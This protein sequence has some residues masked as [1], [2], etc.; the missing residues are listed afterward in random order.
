[1]FSYNDDDNEEV[2]E[3]I[4]SNYDEDESERESGSE[5]E[6]EYENED[7]S[8]NDDNDDGDDD[9]EEEEEENSGSEDDSDYNSEEE[10]EETIRKEKEDKYGFVIN[11]DVYVQEVHLSDNEDNKSHLS[12][13][14]E[15]EIP[16]NTK[17]N[18]NTNTNSKKEKK[19]LLP[20]KIQSNSNSYMKDTSENYSAIKKKPISKVLFN[21]DLGI[22]AKNI[23]TITHKELKD[24]KV[25][26]KNGVEDV[27]YLYDDNYIDGTDNDL[28]HTEDN[29]NYVMSEVNDYSEDIDDGKIYS[30]VNNTESNAKI[31]H[32]ESEMK[33]KFETSD[34]ATNSNNKID[35]TLSEE[36]ISNHV[37]LSETDYSSSLMKNKRE[38]E[39]LKKQG[40]LLQDE[41]YKEEELLKNSTKDE[42]A[43]KK[44]LVGRIMKND[45]EQEIN[46]SKIPKVNPSKSYYTNE[47]EFNDPVSTEI[48]D[49]K[50]T[51]SIYVQENVEFT[52]GNNLEN[53][54]DIDIYNEEDIVSHYEN[55]S[56]SIS[57]LMDDIKSMPKDE[58]IRKLRVILKENDQMKELH[59]SDV[60]KISDLKN[61]IS[62]KLEDYCELYDKYQD[63]MKF[64]N[65]TS[66]NVNNIDINEENSKSDISEESLKTQNR[67]LKSKIKNFESLLKNNRIEITEEEI[68]DNESIKDVTELF[69]L[70]MTNN[71]S[72]EADDTINILNNA[73]NDK[74]GFIENLEKKVKDQQKIIDDYEF[75]MEQNSKEKGIYISNLEKNLN[76]ANEKTTDL[77]NKLHDYEAK[78]AEKNKENNELLRTIREIEDKRKNSMEKYDELDQKMEETERKLME[79]RTEN[80]TL[81]T[82]LRE[83]NKNISYLK[84]EIKDLVERNE[85]LTKELVNCQQSNETLNSKLNGSVEQLK[86]SIKEGVE[87]II[88]ENEE[89]FQRYNGKTMSELIEEFKSDPPQKVEE[90]YCMT[91]IIISNLEDEIQ[92]SSNKYS[93]VNEELQGSKNHIANLKKELNASKNQITNIKDEL[94]STKKQI[95]SLEKE[96]LT[97]K[98]QLNEERN[99]RKCISIKQSQNIQSINDLEKSLYDIQNLYKEQ[100]TINQENE[101]E[102]K[103]LLKK[104]SYSNHQIEN[105]QSKL[106]DQQ[107]K[108]NRRNKVD[109]KTKD[110]EQKNKDSQMQIKKLSKIIEDNQNNNAIIERQFDEFFKMLNEKLTTFI[111]ALCENTIKETSERKKDNGVGFDEDDIKVIIKENS[112]LKR[113]VEKLS[114]NAL[115][116]NYKN[117]IRH[118]LNENELTGVDMICSVDDYEKMSKEDI[119]NQLL[120]ILEKYKDAKEQFEKLQGSYDNLEKTYEILQNTHNRNQNKLEEYE[121]EKINLMD[122]VQKLEENLIHERNFKVECDHLKNELMSKNKELDTSLH[123]INEMKM[124]LE[125]I[126][127]NSRGMQ[128]EID[129]KNILIEKYNDKINNLN[130]EIMRITSEIEMKTKSNE[131]IRISYEN[132]NTQNMKDL[133]N[134]KSTHNSVLTELESLKKQYKELQE[135]YNKNIEDNTNSIL[136]TEKKKSEIELRMNAQVNEN[137]LLS[138]K[139]TSLESIIKKQEHD[140]EE[141]NKMKDQLNIQFNDERLKNEKLNGEIKKLMIE[142]EYGENERKNIYNT[143]TQIDF[144]YSTL[145]S[146]YDVI[147]QKLKECEKENKKISNDHLEMESKAEELSKQVEETNQKYK[148]LQSEYDSIKSSLDLKCKENENLKTSLEDFITL[149]NTDNDVGVESD[150]DL[151]RVKSLDD[152]KDVKDFSRYSRFILKKIEKEREDLLSKVGQLKATIKTMSTENELIKNELTTSQER[153]V[154]LEEERDRIKKNSENKYNQEKENYNDSINEKDREIN[155]LREYE[156]NSQLDMEK[157]KNDL[158]RSKSELEECQKRNKEI[159]FNLNESL[160]KIN[161]LVNEK[162]KNKADIDF[163]NKDIVDR[164]KKLQQQLADIEENKQEAMKYKNQI[165]ELKEQI[166]I[167]LDEKTSLEQKLKLEIRENEVNL[168]IEKSKVEE[169]EKQMK[170]FNSKSDELVRDINT[171]YDSV[172]KEYDELNSLYNKQCTQIN[173]LWKSLSPTEEIFDNK[174]LLALKDYLER[175]LTQKNNKI[176]NLQ[177]TCDCYQEQKET[178]T[179]NYK[180][181]LQQFKDSSIKQIEE[182]CK[183]N[184]KLKKDIEEIKEEYSE[185]EKK[186]VKLFDEK[187]KGIAEQLKQQT[188]ERQKVD[189]LRNKQMDEMKENYNKKIHILQQKVSNLKENL[190]IIK[191]NNK[192]EKRELENLISNKKPYNPQE[193]NSMS[194]NSSQSFQLQQ[195]LTKRSN[196]SQPLDQSNIPEIDDIEFDKENMGLHY[197]KST[198]Y[199]NDSV[200]ANR[201]KISNRGGI[202]VNGVLL[203][204]NNKKQYSNV[205]RS[206]LSE[207]NENNLRELK[208]QKVYNSCCNLHLQPNLLNRSLSKEIQEMKQRLNMNSEEKNI[209]RKQL[210]EMDNYLLENDDMIEGFKTTDML[211]QKLLEFETKYI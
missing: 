133:E 177:H 97:S 41:I 86:N 135:R 130:N 141:I 164:E 144:E 137:A 116:E 181:I 174:D 161:I 29:I 102:I 16:D 149:G 107:E 199:S 171:K 87:S 194:K 24:H 71:K 80:N 27:E 8:D 96:L 52:K 60:K 129:E 206:C 57:N 176:N 152:I 11:K 94:E 72:Y 159:E 118:L 13:S 169:Y 153:L 82:N 163:L 156:R 56:C 111:S 146:E 188:E 128:K 78:V 4:S 89:L 196:S 207:V 184:E 26:N 47:S 64:K 38:Y 103:S 30:S 90:I 101:N 99:M 31:D 166:D 139:N 76:D 132:A 28:S 155:R 50:L 151:L 124:T 108:L 109:E 195:S 6:N 88:E 142:I 182:K 67:K 167:I 70:S 138:A 37:V 9:D 63:L 147:N 49:S 180:N 42:E 126:T 136:T 59:K 183:E 120:L 66:N 134:L 201:S 162:S 12:F 158:Q 200:N 18:I 117:S 40:L 197:S 172:K 81:D 179:K 187:V 25:I 17:K 7:N 19:Q 65:D 160:E 69:S 39:E 51:E 115:V 34:M 119:I 36:I 173:L 143:K 113:K 43:L 10:E 54:K 5:E 48:N 191:E 58:V 106:S 14:S 140:I 202:P 168:K 23:K 193:N 95:C 123:C 192:N 204:N 2:D 175:E 185:K 91:S 77:L 83:A 205:L 44:I 22:D 92:D 165:K 79:I 20:E 100:M 125:T 75:I 73:I 84:N 104:L 122:R 74:N 148:D 186:L 114:N 127:S 46:N 210:L 150:N 85:D 32:T 105:I 15:I 1:M 154:Q 53:N 68:K 33:E 112:E 35:I 203:H 145:K 98:S 110:L 121:Q 21:D 209:T 131:N 211:K 178:M 190:H 61:N 170:N 198:I 93:N 3:K 208:L 45:N 189:E 62:Q 157:L 55:I